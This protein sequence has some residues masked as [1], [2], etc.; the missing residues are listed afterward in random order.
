MNKIIIIL[1]LL[2][3]GACVKTKHHSQV[4]STESQE[5]IFL[6]LDHERYIYEFRARGL[7]IL[8]V[9]RNLD[10]TTKSKF[11]A[12]KS[13]TPSQEFPNDY[14]YQGSQRKMTHHDIYVHPV[15]AVR[16]RSPQCKFWDATDSTQSRPLSE[17]YENFLCRFEEAVY[18]VPIILDF[19]SYLYAV[20]YNGTELHRRS[21][22]AVFSPLSG[23]ITLLAQSMMEELNNTKNLMVLHEYLRSIGKN[24]DHIQ[25]STTYRRS[26]L[27]Y[28][29]IKDTE[30]SAKT[31]ITEYE[32]DQLIDYL[33]HPNPPY[34]YTGF[35][36][37]VGSHINKNSPVFAISSIN[38]HR[39]NIVQKIE[40][41]IVRFFDG[42][43]SKWLRTKQTIGRYFKNKS[44]STELA[45][46]ARELLQQISCSRIQ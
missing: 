9:L 1:A 16:Q 40:K 31:C 41:R 35:S 11:I 33:R 2:A 14:L 32:I 15:T 34:D 10:K 4:S 3:L 22:H 6:P 46:E 44:T 8:Q 36:D 27:L 5:K 17:S 12:G 20:S 42:D 29:L 45:S 30:F 37:L 18:G 19:S 43:Q 7:Q 21:A 24:D 38:S 39:K 23:E 13:T 25:G 26:H 28:D